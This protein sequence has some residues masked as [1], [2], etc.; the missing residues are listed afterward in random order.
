MRKVVTIWAHAEDYL[1]REICLLE[2]ARW[3]HKCG[4]RDID[5]L[6]LYGLEHLN[7][8]RSELESL[9]YRFH[10][11]SRQYAYLEKRYANLKSGRDVFIFN[12][13]MRW[14]VIR[15]YF[16]VSEPFCCFDSDLVISSD[17][18]TSGALK[19][20]TTTSSSTCFVAIHNPDWFSGYE[21]LL[22]MFND[23]PDSFQR[24]WDENKDDYIMRM[25]DDRNPVNEESLVRFGIK[26][27]E[28]PEEFPRDFPYYVVPFFL[29]FR[30]PHLPFDQNIELPVRYR[31]SA[32]GDYFNDKPLA[33]IHFQFLFKEYIAKHVMLKEI[34]GVEQPLRMEPQW[35]LDVNQA[36]RPDIVQLTNNLRERCLRGEFGREYVEMF[37]RRYVMNKYL[38]DGD[39]SEVFSDRYWCTPGVFA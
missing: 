18:L 27:K 28:I 8:S 22:Q 14:M 37:T 38:R 13:L 12:N 6:C 20:V 35:M 21:R 9:G 5:V 32:D 29:D 26:L 11:A 1:L 24:L 17:I 19:G 16:G 23:R 7:N 33:Y 10:D 31:R 3:H 36:T 39:L 15:D 30:G 2:A 25:A 34:F 4:I